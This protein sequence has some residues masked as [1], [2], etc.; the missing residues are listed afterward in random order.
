[1]HTFVEIYL[2]A[3]AWVSLL[4]VLIHGFSQDLKHKQT[5]VRCPAFFYVTIDFTTTRLS[6][7]IWQAQSILAY[8][9]NFKI[10]VSLLIMVAAVGWVS[11]TNDNNDVINEE[12]YFKV[13]PVTINARGV[14][15]FS[16]TFTIHTN[17]SW[18][19]TKKPSWV[20]LD[21]TKGIGDK[22]ISITIKSSEKNYR[23]D[24]IVIS[25]EDKEFEESIEIQQNGNTLSV[26]TGDYKGSE[27]TKGV[28]KGTDN[29]QYAYEHV[30]TVEFVVNG[31]HLASEYGVTGSTIQGALS[32][33]I[34][35]VKIKI[36]SNRASTSFTYR[37]FATNKVTGK[38]VYGI[39][40]TI[41]SSLN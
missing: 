3:I 26:L 15:P 21:T 17:Q 11:C 38:K 37:A 25:S 27:V 7:G 39:E 5:E 13:S 12:P 6:L 19:I 20:S 16:E 31:S 34:H 2:Y 8:M 10:L 41:V 32:D 28:F 40:K 33:G 22:K 29:K 14:V 1:M 23:T 36:Y 30:I 24:N 18:I 9:K 35:V 4:F